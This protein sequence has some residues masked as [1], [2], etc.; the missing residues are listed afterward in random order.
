MTVV[1]DQ[2]SEEI[3]LPRNSEAFVSIKSALPTKCIVMHV[4][5]SNFKMHI[6]VIQTAKKNTC[7]DRYK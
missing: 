2:P 5:Y 1:F 4:T 6:I 3:I 7:Y